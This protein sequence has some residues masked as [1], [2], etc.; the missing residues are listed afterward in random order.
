MLCLDQQLL[1][2]R[3]AEAIAGPHGAQFAHAMFMPPRS[4]VV[5]CFAPGHVNPSVL[6]ICRL[7]GHSYHQVV[8]RSHKIDTQTRVRDLVVDCEHL[9]LV[10]DDLFGGLAPRVPPVPGAT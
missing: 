6:Q 7:L 9:A 10:L 3:D 5:E 2:M 1:A 4:K 8:G